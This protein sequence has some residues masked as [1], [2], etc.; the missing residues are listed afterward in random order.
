MCNSEYGHENY[1]DCEH[2]LIVNATVFTEGNDARLNYF[3]KQLEFQK[4]ESPNMYTCYMYCKEQGRG[5]LHIID[6]SNF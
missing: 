5:H 1:H 4:G 2:G 6:S 3:N